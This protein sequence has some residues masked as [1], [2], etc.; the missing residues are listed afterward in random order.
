V[1]KT[2]VN[3]NSG[4]HTVSLLPERHFRRKIK[5]AANPVFTGVYGT[6]SNKRKPKTHIINCIKDGVLIEIKTP[7][8]IQ[9][10]YSVAKQKT[11]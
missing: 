4:K 9:L 6:F 5:N 8:L 3:L 2:A 11:A 10:H 1:V 7:N